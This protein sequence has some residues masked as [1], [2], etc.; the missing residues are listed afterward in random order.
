[1][2]P[3]RSQRDEVDFLVGIYTRLKKQRRI[4]AT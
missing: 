1:M 2:P 4:Q 3:I